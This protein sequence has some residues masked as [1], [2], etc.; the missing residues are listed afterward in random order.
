MKNKP[1]KTRWESNVITLN[2]PEGS[3]C[4]SICPINKNKV[5]AIFFVPGRN[6]IPFEFN[7]SR[8]TYRE[9]TV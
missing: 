6:R 1:S 8:K 9:L 7:F 3:Y 5:I 2:L 4:V